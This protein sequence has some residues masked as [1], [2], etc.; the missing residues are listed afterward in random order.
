VNNQHL[1]PIL[2]LVHKGAVEALAARVFPDYAMD[3]LGEGG[4]VDNVRQLFAELLQVFMHEH[5]HASVMRHID[6]NCD[7]QVFIDLRAHSA[8]DGVGLAIKGGHC[9]TARLFEDP[10]ER[11]MVSISGFVAELAMVEVMRDMIAKDADPDAELPPTVLDNMSPEAFA[12]LIMSKNFDEVFPGTDED[13]MELRLCLLEKAGINSREDFDKADAETIKRG[14]QVAREL[15]PAICAAT[16]RHVVANRQAIFDAALE[17]T[18]KTFASACASLSELA[19]AADAIA[20]AGHGF[21]T[22][23]D[24]AV[25]LAK[26]REREDL[27]VWKGEAQ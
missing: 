8:E 21:Y 20:A 15:L 14:T 18:I 5:G 23:E 4:S 6:P 9:G 26:A 11:G 7:P 27:N 12:G 1:L 19:K 16:I 13:M 17:Q 25:A 22:A 10:H 2:A 24:R 3:A